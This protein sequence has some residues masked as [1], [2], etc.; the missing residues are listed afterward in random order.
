MLT[1]KKQ[2]ID[3]KPGDK[4]VGNVDKKNKVIEIFPVWS[5]SWCKCWEHDKV[6]NKYRHLA[7]YKKDGK[8]QYDP[9][10]GIDSGHDFPHSFYCNKPESGYIS[11]SHI[12]VS[13]FNYDM[14][15]DIGQ[16]AYNKTNIVEVL[17]DKGNYKLDTYMFYL[18]MAEVI[19]EWQNPCDTKASLPFEYAQIHLEDIEKYTS[20]ELMAIVVSDANQ[21]IHYLKQ[22]PDNGCSNCFYKFDI[23]GIDPYADKNQ[24]TEQEHIVYGLQLHKKFSRIDDV[25]KQKQLEREFDKAIAQARQGKVSRL[26]YIQIFYGNNAKLV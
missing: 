2:A 21:H 11:A 12:R 25:K 10:L 8:I 7:K 3:L 19:Q 24:K 5:V 17:I 16:R 4:I 23:N 22:T 6:K 14:M 18:D 1:I 13:A 9:F 15:A 20:A 26:E